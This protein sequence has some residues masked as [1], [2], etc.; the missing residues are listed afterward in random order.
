LAKFTLRRFDTQ[1]RVGL[2]LS[3]AGVA[4]LLVQLVFVLNI[5]KGFEGVDWEQ[6][7]IYHSANRKLAI[8]A[9][10]LATLAVA[11]AGVG[12]GYNS[13]GERRNDKQGMSWAAFF[14]G[15]AVMSVALILIIAFRMRGE[16]AV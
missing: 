5:H 9:V 14:I 6:W 7:M 3:L 10:S 1:A 4:L 13:A 12:F 11:L 2:A 16:L 8:F 15:A